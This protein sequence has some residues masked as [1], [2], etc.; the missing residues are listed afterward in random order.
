[1]IKFIHKNHVHPDDKNFKFVIYY[2]IS[3]IFLGTALLILVAF[4]AQDY[5][6][7]ELTPDVTNGNL[8]LN[9]NYK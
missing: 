9:E 1:M 5:L 3:D 2:N 6:S 8:Y 4:F 7:H